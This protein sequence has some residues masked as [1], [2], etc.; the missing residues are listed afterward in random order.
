M[1]RVISLREKRKN[2]VYIMIKVR[3]VRRRI[4]KNCG[5]ADYQQPQQ[6]THPTTPTYPP[7]TT[8]PYTTYPTTPTWT[9]DMHLYFGVVDLESNFRLVKF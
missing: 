7:H 3:V 6:P 9:G 4:K 5:G 8:T 2:K 1:I